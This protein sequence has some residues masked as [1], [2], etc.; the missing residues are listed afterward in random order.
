M[1]KTK[2][3]P[4]PLVG[5]VFL[6]ETN[7]LVERV[8]IEKTSIIIT[9]G[10]DPDLQ[11]FRVLRT[12]SVEALKVKVGDFIAVLKDAK[13][14]VFFGRTEYFLTDERAVLYFWTEE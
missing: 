9:A 10:G 14:S 4:G 12:G 1:D 5:D 3:V 2:T 13:R 11:F 7:L 6:L 8:E